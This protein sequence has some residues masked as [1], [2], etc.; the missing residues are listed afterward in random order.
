[1]DRIAFLDHD[2]M[3]ADIALRRP[4]IPHDWVQHGRTAP[5]DIVER[6][7]DATILIVNKVPLGAG[8]LDR[9]PDLR[10]VAVA[11]TG[12]DNVD[13]AACR[14][15]GIAV[16]NVRAYA[17]HTVP[18]HVFALMLALRRSLPAYRQSVAAGAWQDGGQFTLLTHPIRDLHGSTLGIVGRGAI[19]QAVAG[20]ARAFGMRVLFAGRKG[21][22][23]AGGPDH[24]PFDAVLAESDVLSLHCPLTPATRHLLGEPEFARMARR[25]LVINTS[26]GGLIDDMALVRALEG[27]L[28]SGAAVDATAVEPPPPDHP[29]LRLAGRTDFLLTPHIGWASAEARQA[30][31]DQVTACIEAFAAGRPINL[32]T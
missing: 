2:T 14:A 1:M 7:R 17:V 5:A 19:G 24:V 23:A 8:T 12:T 3:G 20:I 32:V 9:L 26:R 25:P 22:E 15:R 6:A 13:V 16:S 21:E 30:V 29:F 28:I 27:G 31:A 18:E 4:A 10:F 11:A